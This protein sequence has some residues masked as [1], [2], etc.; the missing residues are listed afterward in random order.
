M[1]TRRRGRVQ[2]LACAVALCWLLPSA[3]QAGQT[4]CVG[5]AGECNARAVR[6]M[7]DSWHFHTHV[8]DGDKCY[9]CY[10]EV[11]DTCETGFLAATSGWRPIDPIR[12]A[13]YGAAPASEGVKFHRVNG[14]DVVTPPPPPK[15][16]ELAA[17][18]ARVSPGPYAVGD[19]VRFDVRLTDPA[20]GEARPFSGGDLVLVDDSG[21]EVARVPV[22]AS[23]TGAA[24]AD[25]VLDRGGNFKARFDV[26]GPQLGKGETLAGTKTA[27][28]ALVV[29]DCP[30]RGDVGSTEP[31]VLQG[32]EVVLSGT[33]RTHKGEPVAGPD[34]P[35]GLEF[36]LGLADGTEV[37]GAA[38]PSGA[39]LTVTLVV[40]QI[41]VP[42]A[43]A[44]VHLVGDGPPAVCPGAGKTLQVSQLGVALNPSG[45]ERCWTG[46][47]C[48]VT[49]DVLVPGAG[50]GRPSRFLEDPELLVS[51]RIGGTEVGTGGDIAS[52]RLTIDH[53]PEA[54]GTLT[55][56]LTMQA[57]N[58]EVRGTLQVP[59]SESISLSLPSEIDLGTVQGG[60]P[61]EETCVPLDFSQSRGVLGESFHAELGEP[62]E[63]CE[64]R[65]VTVANAQAS[66]LP[67]DIEIGLDQVLPVCLVV[68]RCPS[69]KGELTRTLILRPNAEPFTDQ[70]RRVTVR[71]SVVGKGALAC[72]SGLLWTILAL[73][74]VAIWL[75]GFIRPIGFEPGVKIRLSGTERGVDKAT[76][77][78]LED[79]PGGKRRWYRSAVVHF[80]AGASPVRSARRGVVSVVPMKGGGLLLRCRGGLL[81]QDKRSRRM[82][83]DVS[84]TP[85]E[86]TPMR[87]NTKYQVGNLWLKA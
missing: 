45:P 60:Q 62:C 32:E 56:I 34:L 35:P 75:Y 77:F 84:G 18:I 52:R 30:M 17:D 48:R 69:G 64:E 29:G 63:D 41:D 43:S 80:D 4:W 81:K 85:R 6:K 73:V 31:V 14:R 66:H 26:R 13:L 22:D 61:V 10:D 5:A 67:L 65:L 21:A 2:W 78:V 86:G 82:V 11:D 59:V 24:S 76:G 87:R 3:A 55:F 51:G 25:V 46:L 36:V 57:L 9:E 7:H 20:T 27:D 19:T 54:A 72:W 49:F 74:L 71:Y 39:E 15:Q 79:M 38:V 47:P 42:L 28:L 44:S 1:T 8:T 23:A 53:T 40:P 50:A 83:D 37:R 70:E 33:V 58:Q 12:C 16:V 68:G